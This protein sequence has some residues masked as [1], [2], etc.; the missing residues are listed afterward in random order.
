MITD[1]SHCFF[2]PFGCICGK[3][4]MLTAKTIKQHNNNHSW[5]QKQFPVFLRDS[6]RLQ[7]EREEKPK[8]YHAQNNHTH[9]KRPMPRLIHFILTSP[10]LWDA[11][12]HH[13][14]SCC[15]W[16][17]IF[18]IH[19]EPQCWKHLQTSHSFMIKKS[20]GK[21]RNFVEH[22]NNDCRG[23]WQSTISMY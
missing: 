8:Q 20:L 16:E 7:H 23:K 13:N 1:G 21:V 17:R 6:A 4:C 11:K 9:A 5:N 10:T 3:F 2:F 14:Y 15:V 22:L 12:I 19:K 18:I